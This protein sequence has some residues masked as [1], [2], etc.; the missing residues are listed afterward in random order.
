MIPM[1]LSDDNK[2]FVWR[3]PTNDSTGRDNSV[4]PPQTRTENKVGIFGLSPDATELMGTIT[5]ALRAFPE[6]RL[7]VVDA[8][9]KER[10]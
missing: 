3:N 6:A 8:L 2:P 10:G 5:E 4:R 7:A 9:G 1:L